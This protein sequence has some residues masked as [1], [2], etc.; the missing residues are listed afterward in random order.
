MCQF[1]NVKERDPI[2][3]NSKDNYTL[4]Y[5][6][7]AILDAFLSQETSMV[8]GNF[9]R[10]RR[11]YFD[12]S[13]ALSTRIPVPIIGTN[14]VRYRVGMGC[15]IQ[16]LDA[17]RRKGKCQDQLQWDS[18][19]RTPT[20]YNNAWEAAAGS[21]EAG[22]IYSENGKNVYESNYPT[23]SRWFSRFML[24]RK[25]IMGVVRSQDEALTVDKLLFIGEISKEDWSKSNSEEENKEL[26]LTI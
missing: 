15:T 1:R 19:R 23:S 11:E 21:L 14:K 9:R 22:A 24:G 18:M 17:L 20:W 6:R 5:I 7:Q 12:S 2:H 16:T 4:L 26:E 3:G 13:K 10:L 25:R 8:S